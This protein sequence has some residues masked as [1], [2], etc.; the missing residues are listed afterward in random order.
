M[1]DLRRRLAPLAAAMAAICA[2]YWSSNHWHWGAPMYLPLTSL[3]RAVPLSPWAMPLYCSHFV[4]L[5]FAL[6]SI[7]GEAAFDR[8]LKS[9]LLAAVLSDLIFFVFPTT[10]PRPAADGVLFDA[11]RSLDAPANCFPSQ[12]VALAFLAAWG[13]RLDGRPWAPLGYAWAAVIAASTILVKQHYAADVAGGLALAALSLR[14]TAR[15]TA[16]PLPEG[17][18]A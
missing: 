8:T 3:D 2:A 16:E 7:R 12:H 10:F 6:L 11:I 4:F 18:P 13:L 1:F 17:E 9:V 15:P 5:P 14:L